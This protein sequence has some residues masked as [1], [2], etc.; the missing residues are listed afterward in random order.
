MSEFKIPD[1]DLVYL[2]KVVW[3]NR[4]IYIAVVGL[5]IVLAIIWLHLAKREYTSSMVIAPVTGSSQPSSAGG[6]LSALAR[7]GGVDLSNLSGNNGQYRL[8][9][10]ALTSR[11]AADVL[12]QDQQLMRGLFPTQWSQSED[13]WREPASIIRRFA[14]GTAA[15]LGVPVEPWHPPSGAQVHDYLLDNLEIDDDP[16]SPVVTLR[17]TSDTPEVAEELLAKLANAI[18]SLL[19]KRALAHSTDYIHYLNRELEKVTVTDYRAALISHLFDQEQTRMMAS[20][21]VAFAAQVFSGPSRS[22]KPTAPK[23]V[24]ILIFFAITGALAGVWA[25]AHAERRK[26]RRPVSMA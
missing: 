15:F 26:L 16:K 13:R 11:D 8:F 25:A 20:A 18:D 9:I 12:A 4:G 19:R 17:I 3:K 24:M 6:G 5:F 22:S 7:L 21:N 2:S 23:S 1:I 14:R 10:S